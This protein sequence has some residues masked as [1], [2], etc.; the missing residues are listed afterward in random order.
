ML[1]K[2][3][4]LG[5]TSPGA[6]LRRYQALSEGDGFLTEYGSTI[7]PI[8]VAYETWGELNFGATNAVLVLHALTGDSHA[9]GPAN[10]AHPTPGWWDGLIG[11]GRAIDTDRYFVVCPNVLGGCR[12][13]TG[14]ASIAPDG[15]PYGSRFPYITIRD[16]VRVERSFAK[17]LGIDRWA[18]IVGGSMG[19]M[20]ALEWLIEYPDAAAKGI[21]LATGAVA[22]AE[23]IALSSLQIQMIKED[24]D[25][26]GG[27][28][29]H[30]NRSPRRGLSMARQLAQISYRSPEE[31]EE[32][33]GKNADGIPVRDGGLYAVESY[34]QHHG[35]KLVNRFDANS[36]IRLSEAMN[37]HNV[38][39]NRGGLVAALA[40][41]RAEV[42][43]VGITSDR[44]YPLHQ[45]YEIASLLPS[46]PEVAVVDSPVGHDGFLV[47]VEGVGKAIAAALAG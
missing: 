19:G 46:Q 4:E 13:T 28:Y 23:Q 29:L 12:G 15:K 25:Y 31:F 45:Q 11:P 37:H 20:R 27:D 38:G 9:A 35:T 41:V 8:E 1:Q 30:Y 34:L 39:R 47:A 10:Q 18:A 3:T 16:Q 24:P 22:T 26:C 14:P 7:G 33:F 32:R 5:S 40:S 21:I 44:L 17:A 43:V 42:A 2:A 6:D 36:Y